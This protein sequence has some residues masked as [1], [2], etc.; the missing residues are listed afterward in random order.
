MLHDIGKI[1]VPDN[2]LNKPD[3]L[4]EEE[5]SVIKSHAAIGGNILAESAELKEASNTARHHH[6]RYDGKGYPDGLTAEN[7]PA[8]ARIVSIAD[9]YDAMHSDRIY[10]KG[11]SREVVRKELEEGRGTQ[12]DPAYLDA[13]MQLF[14]S[15]ELDKYDN[16]SD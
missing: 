15:G 8:H 14:E 12:F 5:F 16:I 6:E 10:R 9:A 11:L 2:V 7:I 4:N 1:G 3:K 13:F